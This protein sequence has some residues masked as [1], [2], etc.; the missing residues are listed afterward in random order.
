MPMHTVYT[1]FQ[2]AAVTGEDS[3]GAVV[4]ALSDLDHVVDV[5]VNPTTGAVTVASIDDLSPHRVAA[6]LASTG[7]RLVD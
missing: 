1:V 4:A 6:V 3:A 7:H 5:A 2:A